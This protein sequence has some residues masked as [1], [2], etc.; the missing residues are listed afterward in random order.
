MLRARWWSR[1]DYRGYRLLAL[2][3]MAIIFYLSSQSQLPITDTFD[4]QDKVTHFLAYALLA[5]LTA[6]GLGS[7]QGGLSGR[8]VVGVALFVTL[9]GASDELHQMTVPGRDA[10]VWDL[11]ADSLGGIVVKTE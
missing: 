1:V 4:G 11:C 2:L 3:W 10:S 8:Q 5:F 9:Y 6:R 7:W